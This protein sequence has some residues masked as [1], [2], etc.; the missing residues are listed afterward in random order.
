MIP[1]IFFFLFFWD[2]V[3]KKAA[4]VSAV[5]WRRQD[6]N[7]LLRDQN[8]RDGYRG[9]REV[10]SR[11]LPSTFDYSLRSKEANQE[12]YLFLSVCGSH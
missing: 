1:F 7:H 11:S 3:I 2:T 5:S 12:N 4:A 6:G 8:A 10:N 9:D